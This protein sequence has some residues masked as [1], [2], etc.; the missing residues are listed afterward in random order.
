MT[1]QEYR[2]NNMPKY[3]KYIK[4]MWILWGVGVFSTILFF[5][6]LS[7]S[8]DLPSTDEL[9]NPKNNL[10]T[11]V[12]AADGSVIG[13]YYVEN[14][15]KVAYEDLP[16]HLIQALIA[17]EDKRFYKHAGIDLEALGRVVKGLA[18]GT[19]SKG[20]GSTITQQLAKLQYSNR[21]F[22]GGKI[23]RAIKLGLTKFKEWITAVQLERRYTKEEIIMMYLNEFDFLY[24]AVGIKSAS[25]T[26]FGKQPKDLDLSEAAMLVGMLKNPA[27]YNPKKF[28]KNAKERKETVLKLMMEAGHFSEEEYYEL[29]KNKD[30]Q[31]NFSRKSHSEGIAP[32]FRE[33]LRKE[34]KNILSELGEKDGKEYNVHT[35]GLTIYTTID[36]RM[37]L[38][39]EASVAKNMANNQKKFFKEWKNKDP[40]TYKGKATDKEI[41]MRLESFQKVL[42]GSDRYQIHRDI[43]LSETLS[44]IQQKYELSLRDYEIVRMLKEEKEAGHFAELREKNFLSEKKS[45][46]YRRIMRSDLW[47]TLKNQWAKLEKEVEK[48]FKKKTKMKIFAYND[49]MERDTIMTPWDSLRYIRM[50]L[51]TGVVAV[52]PQSGAIKAWVGGINHKYFKFDHVNKSVE[53]Q[54]GSTFK[55]FVY[56][57]AIAEWG[58]SPCYKVPDMAYTIHKGEGCFELLKDWTPKNFGE[59]TGKEFSLYKALEKSK[60]TVSAYLMKQI[61]C[62]E[63]VRTL[64]KNMGIDVDAL[65]VYGEP[66]VPK[67]PSICLGATDLSVYELTGAYAT[68]ANNG[69]SKKPFFIS[70]IEDK[71]GDVIYRTPPQT[72]PRALNE[73]ANYVMVDM[74]KKVA[75][76]IQG[77]LKTEVG[78][79]TGTTNNHA[80]AWFMGIAPE[81]VIG[82]WVGGDDR[83]IRF[84]STY[85]GQ[86]GILARPIY[87][88]MMKGIEK[89][90]IVKYNPNKRFKKPL[91]ELSIRI[92]CRGIYGNSTDGEEGLTDDPNASTDPGG[93]GDEYDDDEEEDLGFDD[94][95]N[96][97]P[98]PPTPPNEEDDGDDDG[99]D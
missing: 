46:I 49:T 2:E 48:D 18:L 93:F 37:Q 85:N 87:V 68:F 51:Q 4:W 99:F 88:D 7:R 63:P 24:G 74:L 53:R 80:D 43:H 76:P 30:L 79:K 41:E 69:F 16:E 11:E 15:V 50:H 3:K 89:D 66:R 23:K 14:R 42:R 31:L 44:L 25:E 81:I 5:F 20:G 55:P 9:Q 94:E 75:N 27:F 72:T 67:Q 13:R 8:S 91:G 57:T 26:Y 77:Q 17:T 33:E 58:I 82:V 96:P 83:W 95:E 6:F 1:N 60:N 92:D 59:Y 38:H 10:A 52:D 70:K 47:K 84:R 90:T 62:T 54:V 78:G 56:A 98:S 64:V 19:T 22:K 35:D 97:N 32:Y 28:K 73:D 40:W 21:S 61:G 36:P 65:N 86:G 71:N 34:V 12:L 29:V 45:K 39:A